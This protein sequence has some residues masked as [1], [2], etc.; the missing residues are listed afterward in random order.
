VYSPST[1]RHL[2]PPS[3]VNLP[4][5]KCVLSS[6]SVSP[7]KQRFT[8]M[9]S[10]TP[11]EVLLSRDSVHIFKLAVIIGV[12]AASQVRFAVTKPG[13]PFQVDN[14][15]LSSH[16]KLPATSQIG[17]AAEEPG[18]HLH[19]T[20]THTIPVASQRFLLS[21]DLVCLFKLIFII[22]FLRHPSEFLLSRDL[23]CFFKLIVIVNSWSVPPHVPS[24]STA[25]HAFFSSIS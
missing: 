20:H 7:L 4:I 8:E 19:D 6:N 5:Y 16:H 2:H 25:V 17:F 9:V 12:P 21:R 13:L 3:S 23:V 18:L 15:I 1:S 24:S 14:P 22:R 10:V 11:N